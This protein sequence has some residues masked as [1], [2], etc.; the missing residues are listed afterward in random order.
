ML[1]SEGSFGPTW[2]LLQDP[3]TWPHLVGVPRP[4]Q[5]WEGLDLR[6]TSKSPN[7]LL[8]QF[9]IAASAFWTARASGPGT[10][11]HKSRSVG[12]PLLGSE[13]VGTGA[14]AHS[15]SHLPWPLFFTLLLEHPQ[16]YFPLCSLPYTI[17]SFSSWQP[18]YLHLSIPS[19]VL[20]THQPTYLS[21]ICPPS[22]ALRM[23]YLHH[24]YLKQFISFSCPS[25]YLLKKFVKYVRLYNWS[26]VTHWASIE[27]LGS[28][29]G[30]PCSRPKL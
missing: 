26:K 27:N 29:L 16:P 14:S 19:S 15:H 21:F 11:P 18:P 4:L 17:P 7:L 25:I 1:Q 28:E 2:L 8:E 12:W 5:K 13:C 22:L 20:T 30:L 24:L 9:Q 23:I 6:R 10:L 3:P